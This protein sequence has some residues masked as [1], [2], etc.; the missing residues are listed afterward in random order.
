MHSMYNERPFVKQEP[1]VEEKVVVHRGRCNN[2]VYY[3]LSDHV[4]T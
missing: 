3:R 1:N 2:E 4:I